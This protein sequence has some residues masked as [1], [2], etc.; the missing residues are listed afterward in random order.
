MSD[1]HLIFMYFDP[2]H[3][4]LSFYFDSLDFEFC[5][6]P[7]VGGYDFGYNYMTI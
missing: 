2:L 1:F 3:Q 6:L 5:I 4:H 7:S